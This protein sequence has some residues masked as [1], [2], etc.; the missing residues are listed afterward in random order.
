MAH[1]GYYDVWNFMC[2]WWL[3]LLA[4]D[5]LVVGTSGDW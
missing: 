1:F 3:D 5:L 2:W 4:S